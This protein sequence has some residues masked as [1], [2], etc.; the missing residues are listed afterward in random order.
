MYHIT[1]DFY[2]GG[3]HIW[4]LISFVGTLRICVQ[5]SKSGWQIH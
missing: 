2:C 3:T 5:I 1:F 4:P